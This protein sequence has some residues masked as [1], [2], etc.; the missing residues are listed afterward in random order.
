MIQ[1]RFSRQV[2]FPDAV[3]LLRRAGVIVYPTE[4]FLAVG[5]DAA[6]EEAVAR[7]YQVKRR[8]AT[9]P[10]PLVAPDRGMV[11]RYADLSAAPEPLLACW[12]GPLTLVLPARGLRVV[13][14]L[15]DTEGKVAVR[16]TPHP[17]A[18]ALGLA[19]DSL[20]TASSAN[21]QAHRPARVVAELEE[22]LAR[23]VDGILDMDPEPSGGL[24][25]TIVEPL[26]NG[27]VR[28]WREGAIPLTS[29]AAMGLALAPLPEPARRR[30]D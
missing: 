16:V 29:I 1:S 13:P 3:K 17:A 24:P 11:A 6:S 9:K 4:T 30:R 12:P 18:Q 8:A 26:E 25:S 10:L 5:C 22:D 7:I 21:M 2:A 20:L 27:T 23:A 15:L 19:I 14:A 28:V